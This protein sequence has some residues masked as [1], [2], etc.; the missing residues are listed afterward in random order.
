MIF[1]SDKNV[2]EAALERFRY[3]FRE[4]YGKRKIVVTMSGG[5]D[6]TV[7]LNLAHEVMKEM[8]IEKIPVLFLDQE[9]ET[10]MTIEY[11]RYIMHLPWVE[12]YWIQSYFQEWNASKGEWFNVWGPGEK[13][14]REKEPDSYGDLEIPHNQYFSKTLD[15]VHR[16]LFGKD[17][18]TL[19]GVRIE[20]SPARLSGL[21]RGE[22]LPGITWGRGGG[23]YKDG[24]PR[25]L[26]LYPIWDWKVYDVW[27]YIF[28][29][30]LPYCK[31]YNYQFTQKPLRACRVSSLIH[32]QAIRDLGF[33]KEV[34][35]W[36]YDKLV[37][38]V[39]N[40][41]TS[42]HVFKEVAAY[43]YNLPPYFKDWDEY[44]DYLADNLCE[45]KNNAETIKKGYRS[46]KKRNVAKAGRCQECIDYV[47]HQ[48]GYTSA[49]CVIA[50]D[51]GMKRI[52]SVERSLR[53]YLSDNY[54]KIEKAN[55]EY[56][57]SREHQEGV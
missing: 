57:S 29:N 55:K 24:T 2:Y 15:Q 6:S 9:A 16:M 28:S 32:E 12:P 49:V 13:W 31:L 30:K 41:N 3:I 47:I 17:Y 44:V 42:V 21:T 23:Y 56:E 53:Q 45:D 48:I 51:F 5:K 11:I 26:V 25:S 22:C 18:L 50:E 34:D 46:A 4:F 43:C 27:Y 35:P 40:V 19:G 36:F 7:V 20:E 1:Y 38:R 39:A 52:Q 33:I 10:P 37:R 8:G 14:I 54:V